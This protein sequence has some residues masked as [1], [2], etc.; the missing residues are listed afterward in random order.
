MR[1][2]LLV[3]AAVGQEFDYKGITKKDLTMPPPDPARPGMLFDSVRQNCVLVLRLRV[4]V[5]GHACVAI[6]QAALQE[7]Q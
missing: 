7:A 4:T 6:K 5:E 2:L 1:S 3:R